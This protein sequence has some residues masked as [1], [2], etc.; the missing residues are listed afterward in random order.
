MAPA[1]VA[2]GLAPLSF[3]DA[4][5]T[6]PIR[7]ISL[8]FCLAALF[9]RLSVLPELIFY[10]THVN[11]Y[12]LYLVGPL[13]IVSTLL[14]G[15]VQRTFQS[16][17]AWYWLAFLVWMTLAVPFSSW[18]GGSVARVKSYTEFEVIFLILVGG[19]AL[20]WSEVRVIFRTIAAAAVMNLIS[21][22]LFERMA[23]GRVSLESSGTIGNSNDLAAQLL[24]VLP[25][26]L[27]FMMG[28]GRS[29]VVRIGVLGLLMYGLWIILGTASRGALIGL[30]VVFL[31]LLLHASLPQRLLLVVLAGVIALAALAVL[32]AMTL[33]RLGSL[34]GAKDKEA[35]E[36]A[37]SRKYLFQTSVK[38]TI[39]N[40]VFGVGPGQF[41]NFEGKTSRE[42]G[43]HGNWHETHCA[44]TEVSSECGVPAFIFFTAGIGSALLLVLR[45]YRMAKREGYP[46]IANGC[47]CY[48]L[49]MGGY[50]VALVF[51][52]QAYTY[53]LPAMVGL[54]V[55][56]NFA[57]TRTMKSSHEGQAP[58]LA[59]SPQRAVHR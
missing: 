26:L 25:F 22:R 57:A 47:F 24:L 59:P 31:C 33:N 13:A 55:T 42:Q 49:G 48:L 38:F 30:G 44:F 43:L 23:N 21:T 45:T 10:I 52:A 12:L 6:E 17:A 27:F 11:T 16:R 37:E 20:S 7:K 15:G 56:L 4:W 9:L 29:I 34:F 32:P 28:R 19:M 51:L 50:L 1:P 46:E 39:E 18:P 2:V 54:A 3:E 41:S 36:S 53:R 14:K 8:Y 5:E 35:T 40:P 58:A